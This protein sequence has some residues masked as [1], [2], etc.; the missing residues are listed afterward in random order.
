MPKVVE[1]LAEDRVRRA[2][3]RRV[4]VEQRGVRLGH[5][6][7][8]EPL[9]AIVLGAELALRRRQVGLQPPEGALPGELELARRA[10]SCAAASTRFAP[11][12]SRRGLRALQLLAEE[13]RVARQ[14]LRLNCFRLGRRE[15][16]L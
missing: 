7:G 4:L 10:R 8:A 12:A 6:L 15:L 11:A 5:Q 9:G 16:P 1:E 3:R 14:L 2:L 13:G